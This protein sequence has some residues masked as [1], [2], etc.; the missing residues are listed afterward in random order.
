[1]RHFLYIPWT[2]LGL[3]NG[4]RGNRWL[5]NRIKVFKQFVIPSLVN[6]SSQNFTLWCSWR[7]QEKT[8]KYTQELYEYLVDIFGEDRVIFTY[9]G[10]C[11]WDDKYPDSEA[12]DR[13]LG[14]LHESLKYL[15]NY[16]G[17]VEHV[18]MTIQPSDDL[19]EGNMVEKVQR[20]IQDVDAVG[21]QA[22][23]IMNYRTKEMLGYNPNTNPPFYTIKFKKEDFIDPLRHAKHTGPYKSHEYV[24]DFLTYK[25]LEGR[26]FCVGT[27]GENISTHFNHPF[28]GKPVDK[29]EEERFGIQ[30]VPPIKFKTSIRK[31]IMRKLPYGWQ[32]KL[33]Y[34]LGER[35]YA[36]FY[37]FIRN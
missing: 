6:Q 11:F 2:G 23:Y 30:D 16:V 14:S 12:H 3:Y 34:L 4:F 25:K 26:G 22:G 8:N 18:L 31:W 13:L 27:H 20:E 7:R 35:F 37:K 17:D 24:S 28:G 29:V 21:Y 10:V 5:R 9:A 19:Y 15:V 33:R 1:M 36:R 32:R